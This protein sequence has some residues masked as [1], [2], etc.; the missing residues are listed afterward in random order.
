MRRLG[1]LL[2]IALTFLSCP[3]NACANGFRSRARQLFMIWVVFPVVMCCAGL[4]LAHVLLQIELVA[5]FQARLN[6]ALTW[7]HHRL[8]PAATLQEHVSAL[9][10]RFLLPRGATAQPELAQQAANGP[11][12]GGRTQRD[13]PSRQFPQRQIGPQNANAHRIARRELPQQL[14]QVRLQLRTRLRQPFASTPFFRTRSAAGSS[15]SSSSVKP[16]RIVFGSHCKTRAIYSMPPC[17]KRV[18]N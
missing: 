1:L 5:H 7:G 3:S 9:C 16:C 10:H 17:P 8:T 2:T 4:A 6:G 15:D 11:A 18:T 14:P 13:Q 12:T